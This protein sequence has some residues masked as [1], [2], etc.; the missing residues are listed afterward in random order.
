MPLLNF[1]QHRQQRIQHSHQQCLEISSIGITNLNFNRANC[2]LNLP[3]EKYNFAHALQIILL[4][5]HYDIHYDMTFYK[6]T[7]SCKNILNYLTAGPRYIRGCCLMLE[8]RYGFR[9]GA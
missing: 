3:T 5:M 6:S 9:A 4:T 2:I 8:R 1:P 7:M